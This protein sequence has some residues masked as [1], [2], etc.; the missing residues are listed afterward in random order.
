MKLT[1]KAADYHRNGICGEPFRVA[2]FRN[3]TE[4]RDM[5]AILTDENGDDYG[6]KCNG[7]C[8]VLDVAMIA[9]G[10]IRSGEN[11][12]RGDDYEPHLRPLIEAELQRQAD[13]VRRKMTED[14][15]EAETDAYPSGTVDDLD[16]YPTGGTWA[17]E[18]VPSA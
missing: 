10:N 9:E 1:L 7:R 15:E 18:E 5:L 13:E 4:K 2:L 14:A 8:Y 16:R 11:S 6:Q 17:G 3:E 12:W